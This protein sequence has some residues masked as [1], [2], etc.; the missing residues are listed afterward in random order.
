MNTYTLTPAGIHMP[1][2][3]TFQAHGHVNIHYTTA[4]TAAN[5][6]GIHFDPN[7]GHPGGQWIDESFIPWSAFGLEPNDCITWVQV[8]GLN[9]HYGEHGEEP[10]AT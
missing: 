7:N 3:H 8:H 1:E 10:S 2:G 5:S 9:Y 6:T 4:T